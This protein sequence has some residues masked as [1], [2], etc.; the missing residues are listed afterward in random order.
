MKEYHRY[1]CEICERE[2]SEREEALKCEA[3]GFEIHTLKKGMVALY[4]LHA[5]D[6]LALLVEPRH[7]RHRAGWMCIFFRDNGAGDSLKF[8][9]GIT[10]EERIIY[11]RTKKI[12]ADMPAL[13]RCRD[14]C[15]NNNIQLI[16]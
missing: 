8:E 6:V 3:R 1:E 2:Y 10:S 15:K 7:E 16:E 12:D 11:W 9:C 5:P 4:D 13:K 14:Y